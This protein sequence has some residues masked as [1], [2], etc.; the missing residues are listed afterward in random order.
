MVISNS[1]WEPSG[2]HPSQ[3]A[4]LDPD[5][6]AYIMAASGEVVTYAQLDERSMRCARLMR[7]LGVGVGDSIAMCV[8]NHRSFLELCWGAQRAGIYYTPISTHYTPAE[9][10]FLVQNARC[11]VV[12]VAKEIGLDIAELR[13]RFPPNVVILSVGDAMNGLDSYETERD[14]QDD[15]PL[16]DETCGFD[17][18]YT[19]GTTGRPKGVRIPLTG[20]PIT[21]VRKG[22][23]LYPSMGYGPETV[24]FSA[25]PLYHASPLHTALAAQTFGGTVIVPGRFDPVEAL[26]ILGDYQ[27]THSNWVPTHF[28]RLLR[29]PPEMRSEFDV[30]AQICA[31][32]GAAPCPVAVKRAMIEWF[33]PILVEYYGGSEGVGGCFISS[34]EW[35]KHPGSVGRPAMG[36]VHILDADHSR[37]L[38][39]GQTGTIFFESPPEV[40][41]HDQPDGVDEMH[42][43][44][45][46]GTLGDI[47]WVD[48]SGYLFLAD[49]KANLVITGG[50]NVYPQET[51]NRL[52]EHPQ[53]LDAAV[54]GIPNDE[55]GEEVIAVV[56]PTD[57][58]VADANFAEALKAFCRLELSSIKTPRHIDFRPDLPRHENGK[59]YK[60]LVR[61]SY[62]T[63]HNAPTRANVVGGSGDYDEI[64]E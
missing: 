60:R 57:N 39:V 26:K 15:L 45:G 27:V 61:A 64:T 9:I 29:L 6:P 22:F 19:S 58:V 18:L 44:H 56:V 28:I 34:A 47:G 49:R 33:G 10:A 4:A 50:V 37:E 8:G 2:T 11:K 32:H 40:Y 16:P 51:E 63:G 17:M 38:P 43:A 55:F 14:R 20:G 30:R 54:F 52:L 42:S 31:L 5:H 41:Y 23:W 25:G 35:L 36:K 53:V 24:H 13:R 12:L 59:L 46:W 62:L 21:E 48:E 7:E 1:S 3:H